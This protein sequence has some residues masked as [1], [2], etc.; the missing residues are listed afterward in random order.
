MTALYSLSMAVWQTPDAAMSSRD[1]H[2]LMYCCIAIAVAMVFQAIVT[3]AASLAAMKT[4]KEFKALAHDVH[5]RATPIMQ[6]TSDVINDLSPKI[7]TVSENVTQISYTVREKVD[8][9][10]ETITQVN[11]TVG[12]INR[13][14][15]ETNQKTRGQVEHVDRMVKTALDTT[16]EIGQTVANG[17]RGP[18]KQVAGMIA[19]M[20]AGIETLV[21]NFTPKNGRGPG[22]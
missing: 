3:I 9:V 19:G 6:K 1:E 11:R 22:F 8:E 10:G 16:E 12:E 18:L 4:M 13:T 14:V 21:K 17:I 7:R 2:W 15:A 5:S 20:R